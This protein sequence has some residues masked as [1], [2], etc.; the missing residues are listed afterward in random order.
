MHSSVMIRTDLLRVHNLN[1]NIS[2]KKA[3]DYD[4]WIRILEYGKIVVLN[5]RLCIFR[6]HRDQITKK[7]ESEQ[8]E[9]YLKTAVS[10]LKNVGIS[11]TQENIIRHKRFLT[12]D[13]QDLKGTIKWSIKLL[14][15][16]KSQDMWNI[17]FNIKVIKQIVKL[18]IK[19]AVKG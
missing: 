6:V 4:L 17:Y 14:K 1:Y 8:K 9:Y 5:N 2:F 12:L 11:L 15:S 7:S 19:K 16:N 13:T 10:Q 3:Q 18:A